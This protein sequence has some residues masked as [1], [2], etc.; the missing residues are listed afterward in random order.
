MELNR[1]YNKDCLEGMR[2]MEEGSVDFILTSPPYDNL[3]SYET[4]VGES[5]GA[6][7]WEP[8]IKETY[9]VLKDGGVMVWVVNDA[10]DKGSE[11]CTSF[12]QAIYA[13]SVGFNLHDT[14]IYEK[15]NYIPLT[16]NRYEQ[17]WEYMFVFS[18]GTPKTFNPI[19]IP[20]KNAGKVEK[21]GLE[22]RKFIDNK[23]AMRS[24][25]TYFAATK[26]NKIHPNIFKYA[27]GL[28]KTGHPAPFPSKLAEDMV[29]SWS[30]IDDVVLDP[31][32]GSGTTAVEAI[33]LKR[34]FIGFELSA[35]YVDM[36]NARLKKLTGPFRIYGNIGV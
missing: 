27:C 22:R 18:K 16:H 28:E 30:N 12:R 10:T 21:Y 11:T 8:I 29:K 2:E 14:M 34:K 6:S 1:I 31:F 24:G 23:Q 33:K 15:I 17:C 25:E 9:R 35:E 26:E 4:G 3:R 19:L 36:A 20:C 13:T 7:V 32:M 5:W